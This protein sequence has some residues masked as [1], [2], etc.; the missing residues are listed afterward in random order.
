VES[1]VLAEDVCPGSKTYGIG[2]TV[3]MCNCSELLSTKS[4][5]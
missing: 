3:A 1:G 2:L 5:W 4:G